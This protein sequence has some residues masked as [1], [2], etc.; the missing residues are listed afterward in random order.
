VPLIANIS[1]RWT[2][3]LGHRDKG[4]LP[5]DSGPR[6]QQQRPAEAPHLLR[7]C[8]GNRGRRA[9]P[10][11]GGASEGGASIRYEFLSQRYAFLSN[12]VFI[13]T[14][15]CFS[16]ACKVMS[17]E[18]AYIVDLCSHTAKGRNPV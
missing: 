3:A 9:G 11:R 17:R 12:F 15:H 4:A 2:T 8:R 1:E 16:Q 6:S 5:A 10:V 14:I 18:G 7:G 13:A